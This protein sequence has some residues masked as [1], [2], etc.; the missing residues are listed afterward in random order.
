MAIVIGDLRAILGLDSS[1]FQSGMAQARATLQSVGKDMRRIGAGMSAAI[2]APLGAMGVSVVKTAG[3][4]EA[5]MNR[6]QA[7]TGASASEFDALSKAAR[8]MGATTQFTASQAADAIEVLAK[9]G[10]DSS[11]I[12][13]GALEASMLLAASAGTDL[14][15]AGDVA[16]DVMLQFGKEAKDLTGLVDGMNGTLLESKFGFE[17]YRLALGQAGGVAGGIGVSFEDFNATI[18]GTSALFASGSDAGTSFKTFLQRLVPASGPAAEKMKEL[19]L[20]FFD[21]QGNMKSMAEIAQELQDGMSGLT[22]E[23]RNDAMS[24]IFGTD[25]IRTAIGLMN[26]GAAGIDDLKKKIAEASA[27]EQA[28]A[29]LKGFNGELRKLQSAFEA[30]Q[31][32]I[33]DS[34]LL[35]TVTDLVRRLTGFVSELAKSRPEL[36]KWG[37]IIAAIAVAMGPLLIGFG[38]LLAGLGPV[39]GA[40]KLVVAAA[41]LLASPF[42]M[43]A[44]AIA[45]AAYALWHN[46]E[47]VGPWF[48]EL[49]KSIATAVGG[50]VNVLSGLLTGDMP[51]LV[52]GLRA[53]WEGFSSFWKLMWDGIVG[54]VRWAWDTIVT[55][56]TDWLGITDDIAAAW[57]A[58]ATA[59]TSALDTIVGAFEAA[60]KKIKPIVDAM[61]SGWDRLNGSRDGPISTGPYTGGAT[62]PIMPG[63]D[64]YY[65]ANGDLTDGLGKGS[66]GM[67]N[68]G[69]ADG[70]AY[71]Q[72]F[73]DRMGIKSPSRVM[74]EIGQFLSQ[75]LGQ[76]VL[77]G[78]SHVDSAADKVGGGFRD[79]IQ[80]FFSDVT[81]GARSLEEVWS[82]IKSGFS[83]MLS[84][85]AN[86]LMASGFSRLLGGLIGSVDPLAGALRGAGLNAIP[87]FASGV[88]NF[89]GGWARINELG[90]ELVKLPSGSTVVPHGLSENMMDGANGGGGVVRVELVPNEQFDAHVTG[91]AGNVVAQAAPSLVGASVKQVAKSRRASNRFL[92]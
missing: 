39:V 40:I 4:F 46:W 23:A 25:A 2:S 30:L 61:K 72:G 59:V 63:T 47:S 79:R 65:G 89:E 69:A 1:S 81:Q 10:L 71:D 82:N 35:A 12:L 51:R 37:T 76:G 50:I 13:G 16:T 75:G 11:Q 88:S 48:S 26:Q 91:L 90:G 57:K 9:N 18:A 5:S 8:E 87:A 22:D 54:V 45:G 74:M 38:A 62:G 73:R 24:T 28:A 53:L 14:A 77:D 27:E 21:A 85:M 20:E 41:A 7:A 31:L 29:R 32:A 56:L 70:A 67:Y 15:S 42:G 19:N 64:T 86:Q 78:K 58:V 52:A 66:S 84:D 44:A 6:V 92:R 3:S 83:N 55:P 49:G 36:L 60:W 80:G 68:Q 34:G 43:A 17:D 33:A